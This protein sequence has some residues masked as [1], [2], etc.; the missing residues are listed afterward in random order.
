MWTTAKTPAKDR[1]PGAAHH[2][3]TGQTKAK[4]A[5]HIYQTYQDPH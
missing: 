2:Q 4:Q 1:T 5:S 3:G